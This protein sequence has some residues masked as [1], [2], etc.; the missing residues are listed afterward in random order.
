MIDLLA[1]VA[2]GAAL[3]RWRGHGKVSGPRWLKLSLAAAFLALPAALECPLW[4]APSWDGLIVLAAFLAALWGLSRGHGEF[5]DLTHRY[6]AGREE[7]DWPW[8]PWALSWIGSR[9]WYEFSALAVTGLA[10]TLVP[11]LALCLLGDPAGLLLALAG[12]LKA[13][14]Y[15]VGWTLAKGSRATELGEWLTGAAMGL[16]VGV[17][18]ST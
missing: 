16:G 11:G 15:A 5:M 17:A 4:L 14:A 10:A 18:L 1:C 6:G 2:L 3:Y 13:P 12:A 7:A 8:L 9:Y